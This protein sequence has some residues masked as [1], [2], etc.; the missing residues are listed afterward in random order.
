MDVLV[1][2]ASTDLESVPW[3]IPI[4]CICAIS[5]YT[6]Y[7]LALNAFTRSLLEWQNFQIK[8]RE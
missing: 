3:I 7:I 4:R 8:I 2:H 6:Y 1:L 5:S